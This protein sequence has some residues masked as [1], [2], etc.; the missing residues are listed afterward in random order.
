MITLKNP[1]LLFLVIPWTL[2]LIILYFYQKKSLQWINENVS[3]RFKAVFTKYKN[4]YWLKLHFLLLFLAGLS[5]ILGSS[6]PQKQGIVELAINTG[7][8]LFVMDGSFSM[9]AG[10]TI[11]HPITKKKPY[12]RFGQAQEFA[13]DLVDNLPTYKFGLITF[14]GVTVVH[15][16][17]VSDAI[18]IKT[19]ITQLLAHNFENTG[20]N[21]KSALNTIIEVASSHNTKFQVVLISDGEVHDKQP[22]EYADIEDELDVLNTIGIIIHTIGVGSLAGGGVNFFI[23]HFQEEYSKTNDSNS[24]DDSSGM[25]RKTKKKETIKDIATYRS[26][27]ILKKIASETD[28]KFLIVEDGDWVSNL[29]PWVEKITK[30]SKITEQTSGK[31]EISVYFLYLFLVIFLLETLFL[32]G[33]NTKKIYAV[34]LCV[35]LVLVNCKMLKAN[36]HNEKGITQ[37]NSHKLEMANLSFEKS[38]AYQ[39]REYIPIYNSGNVS[40][41]KKEYGLS[42]EYYQKAIEIESNFPEAYYNDGYAL[43]EWGRSELLSSDCKNERVKKLWEQSVFQ[44]GEAINLTSL[45]KE[46]HKQAIENQKFVEDELAKCEKENSQN[47]KQSKDDS[48]KNSEENGSSTNNK[49][50]NSNNKESNSNNKENN[51]KK[52]EGNSNNKESN[53][54]KEESNSNNKESNSINKENESSNKEGNSKN[55]GN[56]KESEKEKNLGTNID[57]PFGQNDKTQT[58]HKEQEYD[59]K[60]PLTQEEIN[61]ITK[62]L[63]R[64]NK[65]SITKTHHRSR[66]Q[67]SKTRT[68]EENKK[69]LKEALW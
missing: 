4:P 30:E 42:H 8:I 26:D 36:R 16:P 15:S 44:F 58:E 14:S 6:G 62:E 51:S 54:N 65:Q 24:K 56:S 20:S 47:K 63:D 17:P 19:V 60:I 43:F 21:F 61:Q 53:S 11:P 29:L 35:F 52:E 34:S 27:K 33:I 5:L 59:E 48:D 28:G 41:E 32:F 1:Y 18:A 2:F 39:F 67:Q 38:S 10:D 49:D 9:L 37:L 66:H 23:N 12:D 64:I 25:K 22:S 7:N 40:M 69:V 45:E 57:D 3:I 31:E 55:D 68:M 13:N 50:N 46:L